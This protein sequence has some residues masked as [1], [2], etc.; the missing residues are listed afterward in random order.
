[1][2]ILK[3]LQSFA[4]FA[5]SYAVDYLM[6]PRCMGCNCFVF[7]SSGLCSACWAKASFICDLCCLR[8]GRL[9]RYQG[10]ECALCI[11]DPPAYDCARSLMDFNDLAK[12]LIHSFKYQDRIE[13]AKFFCS[14]LWNAQRN[15]ILSSDTIV[16]VPM[17]PLKM[18]FRFYNQ[19]HLLAEC[20]SKLS[21]L[22][23]NRFGL[24]KSR[25]TKSQSAFGRKERMEN[26]KFSFEASK[27]AFK[28][29]AVLLVDD[30]LTT[31]TTA[32][33]CAKVLKEAG[34]LKVCVLTV[35][36]VRF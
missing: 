21:N 34:A 19:A 16:F 18:A 35:A 28:G 4:S 27:D 2:G 13:L 7:G 24:E 23:L 1:V 8:C 9:A 33:T 31:G 29:R 36:S 14:L 25:F 15:F 12:N 3:L 26:L 17:H 6:P 30:V 5:T 20:I 32:S 22:P 10:M 11:K